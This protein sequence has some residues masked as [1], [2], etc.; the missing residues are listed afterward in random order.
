[1]QD[2][3]VLVADVV[4]VEAARVPRRS[5]IAAALAVWRSPGL[6]GQAIRFAWHFVEMAIA[7]EIGMM[8]LGFV[9]GVVGQADL[10]SR[11][12]EAYS[13]AMTA[14]MVLPMAAWMLIRRHG[15]ERTAEM[16]AAMIVPVAVLA[17][18]GLA[19]LLPHQAALTGMG[20][21]MWVGMLAAML[22]RWREYAQH[23]H[24][25]HWR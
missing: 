21:L 13:L 8:P 20:F 12:P 17:A 9:L 15:W 1:M 11:S 3:H 24:G 10:H 4:P 18:G 2:N 23:D 19:G 16:A 14:S 7:M 5:G 25:G 6:T 22:F